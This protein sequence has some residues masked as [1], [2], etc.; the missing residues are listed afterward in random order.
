MSEF[1]EL[2]TRR[3]AR[4]P[5]VA[6]Q[7]GDAMRVPARPEASAPGVSSPDGVVHG[8]VDPTGPGRASGGIPPAAHRAP[9]SLFFCL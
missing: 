7:A 3:R 5:A 6:H 8:A 9:G 1:T 4:A 2:A